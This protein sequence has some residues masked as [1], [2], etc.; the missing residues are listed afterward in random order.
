MRR[1][2]DRENKFVEMFDEKTGFYMRSGI[3]E[4]GKDTDIDPFMRNFPQLID[5]QK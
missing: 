2:I 1:Y 5:V 4:D 3:I